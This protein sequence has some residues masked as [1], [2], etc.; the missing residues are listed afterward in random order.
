[1]RA[2]TITTARLVLC[3]VFGLGLPALAEEPA[4]E[5]TADAAP[6]GPSLNYQTGNITLPN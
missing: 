3:A 1:M 4:E 2:F 5:S 6:A